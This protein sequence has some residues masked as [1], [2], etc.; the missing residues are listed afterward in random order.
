MLSSKMDDLFKN[1]WISLCK[2][3]RSRVK[4]DDLVTLKSAVLVGNWHLSTRVPVNAEET[5]KNNQSDACR[6]YGQPYHMDH[7]L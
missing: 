5:L 7:H 3:E 4:L 2:S 6:P 1:G